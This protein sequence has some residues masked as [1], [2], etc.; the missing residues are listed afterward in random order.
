LILAAASDIAE[1]GIVQAWVDDYGREVEIAVAQDAEV[2]DM[3]RHGECDLLITH[4]PEE[5]A[6]LLRI[7]YVE[8]KRE[9]MRDD[10]V[11]LG[12]PGDPAGVREAEDPPAALKKIGDAQAPF[13]LRVDGSGTAYKSNNL[14]A[15]SGVEATGAWLV[16]SEAGMEEVLRQASSEGAYTISDRSNFQRLVGELDLEILCEGGKELENPCSVMLVSQ[17][18]YPDTDMTGARK[19]ADYLLSEDA[20]DFFDLGAWGPPPG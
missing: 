5:E 4:Y 10:Y 6:Q 9:V 7:G 18:T 8:D 13:I 15:Q 17:R 3:A 14:W 19:M 20:R 2:L 12:P 1:T 11:I 16:R